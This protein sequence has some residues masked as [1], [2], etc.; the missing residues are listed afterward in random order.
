MTR[1]TF[2]KG[3]LWGAATS[4]FQIEGAVDEDG[5]GESVWDRFCS[6]P[7]KVRG[8]AT[9]AVAC[10]HYHRWRED[11]ALMKR[12]GLQAYRFSIAWP[13]IFPQGTG[14]VNQRG[15]DFYRQLVDELLAN[16]I[17]PFVTLYHWD[18]PQAL[19]DSG[20]WAS[21]S[22]AEAFV[23]YADAVSRA[24]GDRVESWITHNEPWCAS[25]LG[26][27]QGLH[28]PGIRHWPTALRA[29]HHLLLS[30]GLAAQAL[31]ANGRHPEVGISLNLTPA[32]PASP[33]SADERACRHF[34]GYFNRWF[35]DPVFGRGYPDDMLSDYSEAGHL[36]DLELDVVRPG[37]LEAMAAPL[38]FLGINYYNRN[39]VRSSD[40]ADE[41]NEARTV[42]LAPESE[43]TEMGWEVYPEG[44]YDIITRVHREYAPARIY[45]TENGA[46]YGTGPDATG[47]I[48]DKRR[49][50][51]LRDHFRAAHRS[52]ADGAP[53]AGYFV[54]SLLDNFEWE[55]G[56]EQRFGITWVDYQTLER[57][58]KASALWYSEVIA[59]GWVE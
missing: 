46:S 3:F 58:P 16:D 30:H 2:P 17:E 57:T 37:D 32:V 23:Q 12:L 38:D 20:G 9:G 29:S 59:N 33:S 8:S 19:E 43:W 47:A 45:V 52:I 41:H 18:L 14:E 5:R 24:L 4:S 48:N 6:T 31:R 26:Y 40:I 53:L 44:L 39:V 11:I 7:G 35:L 56:Y 10:D 51:F 1:V 54:W 15:L 42:S 22:T 49:V 21:R 28:A 36:A 25:M 34:D 50:Q 27:Q 55:R 13:R